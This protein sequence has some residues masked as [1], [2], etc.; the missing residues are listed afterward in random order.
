MSES[1]GVCGALGGGGAWSGRY[2]EIRSRCL[3]RIVW[4][5]WRRCGRLRGARGRVGSGCVG[6]GW[7]HLGGCRSFGTEWVV[8]GR[9]ALQLLDDRI[10]DILGVEVDIRPVAE[11]V[12][13][14]RTRRTREVACSR[15]FDIAGSGGGGIGVEEV[16]VD[17]DSSLR[18]RQ[19]FPD[20]ILQRPWER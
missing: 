6:V 1:V 17:F 18:R 4:S 5:R 9:R 8:V 15:N 3:I 11:V 19:Q 10:E 2:P 12:E 20:N 16:E 14:G 13:M 7:G